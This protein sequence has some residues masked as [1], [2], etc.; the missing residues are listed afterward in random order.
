MATKRLMKAT[1]EALRL[2][3]RPFVVWDHGAGAVAGLGVKVLLDL[4]V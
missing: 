3:N 1:V 2:G 4:E